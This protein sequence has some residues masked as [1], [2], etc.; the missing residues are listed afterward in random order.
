M[1]LLSILVIAAVAMALLVTMKLKP[2]QGGAGV[3]GQPWPYQPRRIMSDREQALYH[4]LR[5]A[6]PDCLVFT[7][8][9][10]SQVVTV[11]YRTKSAHA[12]LNKISQKRVDFVV[13]QA[14]STVLAVIEFDDRSH[15]SGEPRKRDADTNKAL[16]DAKV[17]LIRARAVP[18]VATICKVFGRQRPS[19]S[20]EPVLLDEVEIE[21]QR[22]HPARETR[23]ESPSGF[24]QTQSDMP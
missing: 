20:N 11:K 2:G 8:L 21:P 7:Q 18:S 17:K 19:S 22:N 5:E 14:D 12:W 10:L 13:C 15:N 9:P 23:I 1:E 3:D 6:L 24:L 16:R 4:R